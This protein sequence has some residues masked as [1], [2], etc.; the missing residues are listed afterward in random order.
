MDLTLR[1]PATGRMV[2]ASLA[3]TMQVC[4]DVCILDL[5]KEWRDMRDF[6][7]TLGYTIPYRFPSLDDYY[8]EEEARDGPVLP[9]LKHFDRQSAKHMTVWE[10]TQGWSIYYYV[11]GRKEDVERWIQG[12][13][14]AYPFVYGTAFHL[15]GTYASTGE[16]AYRG[17]RST[18]CD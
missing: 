5:P 12:I 13:Y 2:K 1:N 6:Y 10:Q 7:T 4:N 18:T 3:R 17:Y 14:D 16:V 9:N 15:L 11:K 8:T